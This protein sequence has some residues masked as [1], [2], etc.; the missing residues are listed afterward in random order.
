[1]RHLATRRAIVALTL[2]ALLF[3]LD[4]GFDARLGASA[5]LGVMV[6]GCVLAWVIVQLA[7]TVLHGSD[8][9]RAR[10]VV[11]LNIIGALP[12]LVMLRPLAASS[13]DQMVALATRATIVWLAAVVLWTT[14]VSLSTSRRE[15]RLDEARGR[16]LVPLHRPRALASH[17]SRSTFGERVPSRRFS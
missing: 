7:G 17:N 5:M 13:D 6:A 10:A 11:A 9:D 4:A 8:G 2:F 14:A 1:M 16:T 3:T 12:T 15:T